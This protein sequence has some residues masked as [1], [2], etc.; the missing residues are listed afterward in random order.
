V[1]IVGRRF[2]GNRPLSPG[3]VLSFNEHTDERGYA[4]LA[5]FLADGAQPRPVV[6]RSCVLRV[7]PCC[8]VV[9][10][11]L[12]QRRLQSLACDCG[13]RRCARHSAH[14]ECA[15]VWITVDTVRVQPRCFVTL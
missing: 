9:Q 11:N 14:R 5:A 13:L 10:V 4:C 3:D 15:L 2:F 12:P 7:L 1:Y 6:S 8:C